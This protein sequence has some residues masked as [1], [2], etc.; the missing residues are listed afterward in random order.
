MDAITARFEEFPLDW[1]QLVARPA[2]RRECGLATHAVLAD[3]D[4][5][6]T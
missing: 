2:D 3:D 4:V 1:V 6:A 5:P